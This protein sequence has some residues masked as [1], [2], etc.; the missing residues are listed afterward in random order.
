MKVEHIKISA[1]SAGVCDAS[2]GR[3]S[4]PLGCMHHTYLI[5]TQYDSTNGRSILKSGLGIA[6]RFLLS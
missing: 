4:F 1:L 5:S 6:L 2:K 3:N